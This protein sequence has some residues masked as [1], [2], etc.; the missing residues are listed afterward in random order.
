MIDQDKIM[1][2]ASGNIM[3]KTPQEAYD[4]IENMTQHHF[5]RDAKMYYDT[6]TGVIAHYSDTT[7]ASI[8][9]VEVLEKQTAYNIQ[10]FRHQPRPEVQRL[11][12]LL[13]GSPTPSSDLI[14]ESLTPLLT[15]FGD[16]DSLVE[17]TDTLLSHIDY[18]FPEYKIFCFDM[19]EKS[20]GSTTTHS[21]YSLP[22][23]DAFYFD[24]DHI[25]D[26]SSGSTTTHS[27]FSLT[28]YDSF[29]F[30]LSI[31]PFPP[32][33]RSDSHH[34]EFA[35][36]LAHIISSPE[37]DS[38]YFDIEPDLGELTILFEENISKDSTKELTISFPSRNED[39]IFDPGIFIIKGVQSERFHILPLDDFYSISFVSAPLFLTDPPEIETFLSFL[40]GNKDK[41]FNPGIL[42]IN[43]VF[44]FTRKTPH[45]LNDNFLIDKFHSFSEIS[46]MAESL[47]SFYPKDKEI[48]GESS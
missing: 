42:F 35:D 23:Y 32:A 3:Q 19:E 46:L 30:D 44:S 27:D 45:L 26:K 2:A 15:P 21:D 16:S 5:Q 38:F 40:A 11:I 28:E 4:L 12:H 39:I 22:D 6:T 13:S 48:Q 20:S 7:Y 14:V 1:M 17:E 9:P 10:S 34:E 36:E 24:G 8:A 37:Y 29:I 43:G 25:E 31:D 33:D 18:S 47:V 41:V